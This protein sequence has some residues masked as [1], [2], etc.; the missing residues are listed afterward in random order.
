MCK[1][2]GNSRGCLPWSSTIL[3][4][5]PV[6]PSR[7]SKPG[8]PF[9]S[10][11]YQALPQRFIKRMLPS[12][13]RALHKCLTDTATGI[14]AEPFNYCIVDESLC[15]FH[16]QDINSNSP[17]AAYGIFNQP[18]QTAAAAIFGTKCVLRDG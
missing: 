6:F 10:R 5:Q 14:L 1:S 8:I 9:Q 3:Q 13:Q 2:G 16:C 7:I 12:L 17:D 11:Q 18:S 4:C 15:G